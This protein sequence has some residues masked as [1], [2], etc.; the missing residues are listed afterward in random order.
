M[1]WPQND[2]QWK[3]SKPTI[4]DQLVCSQLAGVRFMQVKLTKISF[5]MT[6][7]KVRFIPELGF[8][9]F[10]CKLFTSKCIW[11]FLIRAP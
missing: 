5:I 3:L 8:D 9:R 10:N 6:L 11:N 7:F 4:R 1:K 2:I